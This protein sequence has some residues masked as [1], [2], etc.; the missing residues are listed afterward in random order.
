MASDQRLKQVHF[1]PNQRGKYTKAANTTLF[2]AFQG[3][4]YCMLTKRLKLEKNK[5]RVWKG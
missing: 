5:H 4:F 1:A 3:C 2:T